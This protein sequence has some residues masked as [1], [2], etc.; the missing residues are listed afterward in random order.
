M[1]TIVD[2]FDDPALFGPWF[3]GP[4]WCLWRAILKAAFALPMTDEEIALFRG[5]ADR[6]PP[7]KRVRELW[8]IAGRRA[9]KDSIASFIAAWTMAF[10]NYAGLLRP[11]EQASVMCLA[12]DREQAKIV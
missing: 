2:A 4:S 6:D 1:H 11:G 8:V 3:S 7:R 10:M 5:V 12:R 9:G